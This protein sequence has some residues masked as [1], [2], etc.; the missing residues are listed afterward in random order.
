VSLRTIGDGATSAG[1]SVTDWLRRRASGTQNAGTE[2]RGLPLNCHLRVWRSARPK[3]DCLGAP[4]GN[5]RRWKRNGRSEYEWTI[6][7]NRLWY[8]HRAGKTYQPANGAVLL[9]IAIIVSRALRLRR[10]GTG[11]AGQCRVRM[12]HPSVDMNVA[13]GNIQ[14]SGQREERQ[15]TQLPISTEE[16]HLGLRTAFPQ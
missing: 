16:R 8:D 6:D 3:L 12:R 11:G 9:V 15:P 13:E 2:K 7:G 1:D 5:E 4:E 14:L 10:R